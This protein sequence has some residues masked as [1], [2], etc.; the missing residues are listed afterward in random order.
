MKK[1]ERGKKIIFQENI[2]PLFDKYTKMDEEKWK[3]NENKIINPTLH[4]EREGICLYS[5]NLLF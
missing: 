1:W 5:R 2:T 3:K 4:E